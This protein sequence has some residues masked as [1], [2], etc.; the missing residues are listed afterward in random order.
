[1]AHKKEKLRLALAIISGRQRH[2]TLDSHQ[3]SLMGYYDPYKFTTY[4]KPSEYALKRRAEEIIFNV[5]LG[6]EV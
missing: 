4:G 2:K 3:Q 1:M 6:R 5:I